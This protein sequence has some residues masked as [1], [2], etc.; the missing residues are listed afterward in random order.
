[1]TNT[2]PGS[3]K[4]AA[5]EQNEPI[6]VARTA[7]GKLLLLKAGIAQDA[8][9]K[10]IETKLDA[11]T[12]LVIGSVLHDLAVVISNLSLDTPREFKAKA[13]PKQKKKQ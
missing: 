12:A 3:N 7:L 4:A 6:E 9:G 5:P 1:M 11:N 2:K 8:N 13:K 10:P